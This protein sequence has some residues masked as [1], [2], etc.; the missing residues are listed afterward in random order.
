I[1]RPDG[2]IDWLEDA[3]RRAPK[4]EDCGY[5]A[6]MAGIDA[7]V[8]GRRTFEQALAFDPWPYGKP[9]TVLSRG[10][11]RIPAPLAD[12]VAAS[13]ESPRALVDRLSRAGAK[14]LY[15]DGGLT[16][17]SF[18]AAGLIDEITITVVPVLLGAGRTLFGPLAEDVRLDHLSTRAYE[19]GFVQNRYRIWNSSSSSR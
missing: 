19:F 5:G 2:S 15:V 12:K 8:M 9:V 16:I 11:V 4:G 13:V 1:S 18:L 10:E 14:H 17:Q 3:N 7:L 6:F